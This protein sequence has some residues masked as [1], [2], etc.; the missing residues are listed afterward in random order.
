MT[1]N[2]T[3]SSDYTD[4][5]EKLLE[6]GYGL[7]ASDPDAAR[8][9]LARARRRLT[10]D[11][12]VL[13]AIYEARAYAY[14][15]QYE[16]GKILIAEVLAGDL[17]KDLCAQ[18]LLT[19]A[20]L[21]RNKPKEA[22]GILESIDLVDLEPG[23]RARVHNQLAR[24]YK[25]LGAYDKALIEYSGAAAYFEEA[26][27]LSGAAHVHNNKAGVF[28]LLKQFPLAHDAIDRALNLIEPGDSFIADFYDRKAEICNDQQNYVDGERFSKRALSLL[29]ESDRYPVI[30][31]SLLTHAISLDGL[32]RHLESLKDLEQAELIG[33]R[34]EDQT[35]LFQAAN[36]MWEVSENLL[37]QVHVKATQRALKVANNNLRKAAK[38]TNVSSQALREFIQTNKLD[39]TPNGS[40][41]PVKQ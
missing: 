11:K 29:R 23:L 17:S 34:L 14:L 32:G 40:G 37:K 22:L 38:L 13:A 9:V 4:V 1:R 10:G 39:F 7:L 16:E 15:G 3:K 41:R 12:A 28:R 27:D 20:V 19:D 36:K 24:M 35:L 26:H 2:L 25:E 18:A 30:A 5:T 31:E 6:T 8:D 21:A 33:Y